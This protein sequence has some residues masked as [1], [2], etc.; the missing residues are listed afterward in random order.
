MVIDIS[1]QELAVVVPALLAGG[2]ITGILS[3]LLGVGGG[4]IL[5]PI[6]YELFRVLGVDDA[7]RMHLAVGTS[8]AI[9]IPTSFRSYQSHMRHGAAD[10]D[11]IRQ[12]GPWVAFGVVLGIFIASVSPADALKAVFV[13]SSV[14]LAAKLYTGAARWQLGTTLPA[15]PVPAIVGLMT[16]IISTLIGIGGGVYISGYMTMYG[17]PIHQA[18]ATASGFGPIIAIPAAIGYMAAGWAQEGLPTL[19]LGYVSLIGLAIVAPASVLAAPLGVRLAHG[20]SRRALE[21]A[22]AMF[23]TLVAI[24]FGLSIVLA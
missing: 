11:I 23:L 16:G 18:V 5:V 4:G 10:K 9:I 21:I 22:F 1:P 2:V 6:L 20:I 8:L 19:S 7:V 17:R 14:L 12:I 24:R 13:L 15:Q 3:G